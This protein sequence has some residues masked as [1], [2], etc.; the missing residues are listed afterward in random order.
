MNYRIIYLRLML[1]VLLKA[2]IYLSSA[3]TTDEAIETVND[4]HVKTILLYRHGW[5]MSMP[6]IYTDE[7]VALDLAFDYVD[8]LPESYNYSVSNCTFDWKINDVNEHEYVKDFNDEPIQEIHN[9]INTTRFYTHFSASFPNEELKITRSGNYLLKVYQNGEPEKILF[10][11]R[12]CIADRLTTINA[13]IKRP[14]KEMQEME[15]VI[16]LGNLD[17]QNPL[18]E[19]KT[20]IIKNFDWKNKIK[21]EGSPLLQDN[22]LVYN[23]PYQIVSNGGNEFRDFD[24]KNTKVESER[25]AAI[26]FQNPYFSFNLKA[27]ESKQFKPY[28]T[29][30]DLN[31]R[32]YIDAPDARNRQLEADYV[33]VH[34]TLN[35]LQ[36]YNDNVYIYGALTNFA[37]DGSSL[38]IYHAEKSAYEKTL[39]LKQ[40]YYNYLYAIKERNK[41]DLDFETTEGSHSETENDYLIFVYQKNVMSD[42]DRLIGFKI[43]NS[44]GEVK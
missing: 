23:F 10:T 31:G 8:T 1:G 44:T 9:S 24:T 26:V 20:T 11:R 22:K 30:K 21:I 15:L 19:I 29:S 38:M 18:G 14:D 40:G 12:F 27:D 17:L 39:L 36:P 37:I 32:Y 35:A 4:Q 28:L 34:F 5:E 41:K 2:P 13:R 6:V 43:V 33:Y 7:D 25:I 42:F 3:Q 16:D